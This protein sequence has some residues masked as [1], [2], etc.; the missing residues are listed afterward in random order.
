MS[1]F[2]YIRYVYFFYYFPYLLLF[3][4]LHLIFNFYLSTVFF[5]FFY[6][7]GVYYTVR[8]FSPLNRQIYDNYPIYSH[9]KPKCTFE[10]WRNR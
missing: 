9:S 10:P 7:F 6:K 2:Y 5:I 1:I 8:L 3:L 4:I